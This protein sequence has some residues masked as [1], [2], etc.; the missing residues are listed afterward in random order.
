M[1]NHS[2]HSNFSPMSLTEQKARQAKP[3]EKVYY[4]A[5]EDGLSL[6]VEPNGT[7]SWSYRYAIIGTNKRPRIKLGVFPEMNLKEARAQRD[8]QKFTATQPHRTR[9]GR[10]L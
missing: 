2:Y 9:R 1:S 6:K 3:K 8:E 7:K 5:D 4:L 10:A